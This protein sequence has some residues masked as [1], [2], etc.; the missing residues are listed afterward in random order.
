M[1]FELYNSLLNYLFHDIWASGVIPE[2]IFSM[3]CVAPELILELIFSM[4]F[5]LLVSLPNFLVP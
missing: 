2:L 1:T 5:G 3:T 4:T